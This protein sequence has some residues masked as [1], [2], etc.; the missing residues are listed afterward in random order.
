MARK[1]RLKVAARKTPR[2][3]P[4]AHVS[5]KAVSSQC[6]A[7]IQVLRSPIQAPRTMQNG[8]PQTVLRAQQPPVRSCSALLAQT[9]CQTE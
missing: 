9:L 3:A 5:P 7:L 6:D 2:L 8:S 1:I 4:L